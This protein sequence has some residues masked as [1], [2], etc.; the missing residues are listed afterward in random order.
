MLPG[1]VVQVVISTTYRQGSLNHRQ[2]TD[3]RIDLSVNV[4]AQIAQ[5]EDIT[6]Y[7]D[8]IEAGRHE[9]EPVEPRGAGVKIRYM[10]YFHH[11]KATPNYSP[12]NPFD[13][14]ITERLRFPA[15]LQIRRPFRQIATIDALRFPREAHVTAKREPNAHMQSLSVPRSK[16]AAFFYTAFSTPMLNNGALGA[17]FGNTITAFLL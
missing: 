14:P 8:Q 17:T 1:M 12:P 13:P 2:T 9:R 15:S 16:H 7:A 6:C 11:R 10:E 5:I 4:R 3:R